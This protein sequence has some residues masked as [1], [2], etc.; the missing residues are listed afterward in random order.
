MYINMLFNYLYK[1]YSVSSNRLITMAGGMYA[2]RY[3]VLPLGYF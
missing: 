1:E 2:K 3:Y